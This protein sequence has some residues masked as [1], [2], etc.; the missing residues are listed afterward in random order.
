MPPPRGLGT[1]WSTS[2]ELQLY[3]KKKKKSSTSHTKV[4]H[5]RL[6]WDHLKVKKPYQTLQYLNGAEV[7]RKHYEKWAPTI[8]DEVH[9]TPIISSLPT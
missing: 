6:K 5:R 2:A 7:A 9:A 1:C 3:K 8:S 4:E